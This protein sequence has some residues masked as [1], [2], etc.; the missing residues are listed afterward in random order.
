MLPV[1]HVSS[2]ESY[3]CCVAACAMAAGVSYD[4]MR[5][6]MFPR[7]SH[8]TERG[9]LTRQWEYKN[10]IYGVT[11]FNAVQGFKRLGCKIKLTRNPERFCHKHRIML[12]TYYD[13]DYETT[14][15]GH[16]VT[17]DHISNSFYDP[18]CKIESGHM[19]GLRAKHERT[20][21]DAWEKRNIKDYIKEYMLG[22]SY[23]RDSWPAIVIL[24]RGR[25][26]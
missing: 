9:F 16:A 25:R 13:D 24:G 26:P 23:A 18:A 21:L 1:R 14:A 2:P 20:N 15:W 8:K 10:S 3:G 6:A 12:T 19:P 22:Y 4:T 17:W 5:R 7:M 11:P